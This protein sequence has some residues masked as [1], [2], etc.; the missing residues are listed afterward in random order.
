MLLPD[1]TGKLLTSCWLLPANVRKDV[2][3]YFLRHWGGG[4]LCNQC[5]AC[6]TTSRPEDADDLFYSGVWYKLHWHSAPAACF[7]A[8]QVILSF[9]RS[10]KY[11]AHVIVRIKG[12]YK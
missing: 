3:D 7:E 9:R 4:Y 2:D 12:S 5:F 1:N 11:G 10:I 6:S 8:D